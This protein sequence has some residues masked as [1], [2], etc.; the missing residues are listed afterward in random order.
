M[1]INSAKPYMAVDYATQTQV[2]V[3]N[4]EAAKENIQMLEQTNA[5]ANEDANTQDVLNA[6]ED[7][8]R[9][10][11]LLNTDIQFELHEETGR[12]MVQVVDIKEHKVIKEFPPHEFLDTV[13]KIREYV[14]ILLDKKI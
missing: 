14:G 8:T 11:Q 4:G 1:E 3:A 13:A 10:A 5:K 9:L 6:T 7:M 12:L 2:R